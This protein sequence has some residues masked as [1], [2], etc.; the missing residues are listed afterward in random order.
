LR[1]TTKSAIRTT[2]ATNV[3]NVR[4]ELFFFGALLAG[5]IGEDFAGVDEIV[6]VEVARLGTAGTL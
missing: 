3:I 6:V 2:A 4:E 1:E 5:A